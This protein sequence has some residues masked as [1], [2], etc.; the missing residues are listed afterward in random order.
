MKITK[1]ILAMILALAAIVLTACSGGSG[2][3]VATTTE[4]LAND[5]MLTKSHVVVCNNNADDTTKQAAKLLQT[6]MDW[7]MKFNPKL[8]DADPGKNAVVVAVD[9]SMAKEAFE[10]KIKG[11]SLYVTAGESHVLLYAIK[12]LRLALLESEDPRLVTVDMCKK[13]SGSVDL[14][15][16]PFTFISQNILFKNIEG[17]NTVNERAPRFRD[18]ILEY[19]PDI[20]GIQE[21]SGGWITHYKNYFGK[22]YFQINQQN[23][24][25]LFRTDRYE[26]V[27]KGFLWLSP[28]PYTSSQFPGDSGPRTC[29]WAIVKDLITEKEMFLCNCHLDWNNDTQ[30][31]LQ[32]EVMIKELTP[33][34]EKYP[35]FACGDYNSEPDGPIYARAA[36]LFT[37]ARDSA[38]RDLSTVDFT[39]HTFGE[40]RSFI[41]Y[42]FH[43]E[44]F[45][46]NYYYILSDHYGGYVSDHY[47]VL[48]EFCFAK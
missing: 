42:I 12:Q 11:S 29:C 30:R 13:L 41:D 39:C 27:D 20:L 19:Q 9:E 1:R 8:V 24:T 18:M 46:T 21:N 4:A 14:S 25:Y 38:K 28:T 40:S 7:K 26:L 6:T 10:F 48:A 47:G 37:H 5:L 34:F 22:T 17:G 35:T 16:L 43:T 23:V 36:E 44:D 2:D 3:T 15:N 31:A 45:A 33:Y 32:L